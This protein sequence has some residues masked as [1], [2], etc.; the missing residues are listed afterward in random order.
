M[1][2]FNSRRALLFTA[3]GRLKPGVSSRQAEQGIRYTSAQLAAMYPQENQGRSATLL[4]LAEG[5]INPNLRRSFVRVG[6]LMGGVVAL[7]LLIACINVA[8]LLLVRAG[9][10]R[11][12]IAIRIS[13]GATR[14]RVIRQLLTESV[15]LSCIGGAVGISAGVVG[16]DDALV[17]RPPIL[18][19]QNLQLDFDLRVL[20]FTVSLSIVTG[21]LFGLV[22]ALQTSRTDLVVELKERT[23]QFVGAPHLG[24]LRN[25]LVVGQVALSLVALVGAGLF[26][27][28][29]Q[30]AERIDPGFER[31]QMLVLTYDLAFGYTEQRGREFHKRGVERPVCSPTCFRRRWR[32]DA[33]SAPC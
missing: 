5:L 23:S 21:L 24:S 22:P 7:V 25:L 3:L 27:R 32:P 1:R 6:A 13:L 4:P 29:L 12:E 8:N 18:A 30:N 31:Q 28:S 15:L 14:A 16:P 2:Q 9:A 11:K 20:L 17:L 19:R 33:R 26:V 10:R